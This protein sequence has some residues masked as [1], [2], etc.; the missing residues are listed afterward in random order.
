MRSPSSRLAALAGA[1][2]LL[3]AGFVPLPFV[4]LAPGP[5][6]DT[7]GDV[8]GVR[9]V[10]ISGTRTY[11]SEGELDMT[12]VREFGG[13][14]TGVY[15]LEAMRAW[16]SPN[17]R[18]VPRE[19]FYPDAE[20]TEEQVAQVAAEAFRI[21]Q[22]EATGAALNY[23]DIPVTTEVVVTTVIAD[24][25]ADGVIRA[26]SVIVAV[27]GQPVTSTRATAMA[28]RSQPVGS[29]VT[30][31]LEFRSQ[32]TDVSLVTVA[33]PDDPTA[34][35][36]GV[37][38]GLRYQA[39]F[40]IRFELDDVGGPSAGLMFALALVDLLTPEDLTDG[41][42]IAGTGTIDADGT[43]G[44][45]GGA[46]QKVVGAR[47]DGAELFLVPRANCSDVS[48]QIPEGIQVVPVETLSDAVETLRDFAAGNELRS[49]SR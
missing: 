3:V 38:L 15:L 12:T 29:T 1:L 48:G 42:V 2:V 23:L 16:L 36:I 47:R 43:V 11:P 35:F 45:I 18:V 24:M 14:Q 37:G 40:D 8:D 30:V 9:L 34:S 31:T 26:G 33:N 44:P 20:Q 28:V 7:L 19:T 41:V 21:S 27:N 4:I 46:A 32:R 6:Y 39:P 22:A 13:P 10:T 49:C 25:P 5:T 17:L